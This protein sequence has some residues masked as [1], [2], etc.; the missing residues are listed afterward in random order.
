MSDHSDSFAD[1]SVQRM[2]AAARTPLVDQPLPLR[3]KQL[4][5]RVYLPAHQPGLAEG[6][7]PGDRIVSAS[8]ITSELTQRTSRM[9][10]FE[11]M[12]YMIELYRGCARQALG[13]ENQSLVH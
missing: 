3:K 9:A 11:E 10:S 6:G 4:R 7:M 13:S 1:Q 8:W 12:A 2:P 5:C